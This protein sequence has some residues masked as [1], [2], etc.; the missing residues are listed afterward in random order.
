MGPDP[1]RDEAADAEARQREAILARSR[2]FAGLAPHVLREL[3]EA[4]VECRF[5][6]DE[7]FIRQGDPGDALMLIR[8]G[9]AVARI[10]RRK[11][12][13]RGIAYFGPGDVVGEMALLI[14]EPRST[15]VVALTDIAALALPADAFERL[16]VRHPQLGVVLTALVARRLGEHSLDGLAGKRIDG[17]YDIVRAIGRGGMA[18][19]YEAEDTTTGERVA[20]KMMS[21][22][23]IYDPAALRRFEREADVL[24]D[25]EHPNIARMLGRLAAYRTYFIV[26][27]YCRGPTLEQ[28]IDTSGPVPEPRCRRLVGQ[29]AGALRYLHSRDVLHR[30]LKPSNVI[31]GDDDVVKVTDFGLARHTDP[32]HDTK[33]TAE[34]AVLGTPLYLAP[35]LFGG[36]E[37]TRE[38][39]LYALGCTI[40]HALLGRTPFDCSRIGELIRRKATYT[41]PP[42]H[43]LGPGIGDDL[44]A[45]LRAALALEPEER[46]VD[47]ARLERWSQAA[48]A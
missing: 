9:E 10:H 14:G 1:A 6:Q 26:L 37:H 13:T 16:A 2:P 19:V 8:E 7:T 22:R 23:L 42:A 31:V 36:A 41:V 27:E 4:M 17:R 40:L 18:V 3:A 32:A 33:V 29:L 24:G 38:S 48:G 11:A 35:E 44:H 30:D 15:D 28:L 25:L 47:L 45:F 5:A 34:A 20:L 39:D 21:H 12:S 43:E 46:R